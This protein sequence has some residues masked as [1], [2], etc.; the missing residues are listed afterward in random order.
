MTFSFVRIS[1]AVMMRG[2]NRRDFMLVDRR[3][4]RQL[5]GE[6]MRRVNCSELQ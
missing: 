5:S 1:N 2:G 6:T 4:A 3:I